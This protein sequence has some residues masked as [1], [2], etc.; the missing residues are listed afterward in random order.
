MQIGDQ[1]KKIRIKCGFNQPAAAQKIGIQQSYLSKIENNR[2]VPSFEILQKIIDAYE[3]EWK[4][5]SPDLV[6]IKNLA[7]SPQLMKRQSQP[8][9]QRE[10]QSQKMQVEKVAVPLMKSVILL[11]IVGG[12]FLVLSHVLPMSS[13]TIVVT[14]TVIS[15]FA[16]MPV[17]KV[18]QFMSLT[19]SQLPYYTV[20][21]V[22]EH[23]SWIYYLLMGLGFC[24]WLIALVIVWIKIP[25]N[26]KPDATLKEKKSQKLEK[27]E[28]TT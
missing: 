25:L 12:L 17:D 19:Y 8:A 11:A 28:L 15:P 5:V 9:K 16:S 4:D 13:K 26:D 10:K 1:L 21:Q 2:S 7:G 18:D 3:V 23:Y 20:N 22:N 6:A 14:Q 27:I 24:C